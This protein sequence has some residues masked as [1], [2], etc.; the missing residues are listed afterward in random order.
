M[1]EQKRDILLIA[2]AAFIILVTNVIVTFSRYLPAGEILDVIVKSSVYLSMSLS[3]II[4]GVCTH[5]LL[6][7]SS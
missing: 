2:V 3:G 7:K 4:L 6:K 5:I 1:K